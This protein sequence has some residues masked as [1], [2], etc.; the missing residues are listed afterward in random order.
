MASALTLAAGGVPRS[1]VLTRQRVQAFLRTH[2]GD[3]ALTVEDVAQAFLI[4]KR[5]L[6]RLF[7]GAP[8]GVL[9]LLRRIRAERCTTPGCPLLDACARE[10]EL[11]SPRINP[12]R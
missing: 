11:S 7:D 9:S 2:H 6:C 3:P 1:E 10:P 4:S 12:T 5:M 8:D